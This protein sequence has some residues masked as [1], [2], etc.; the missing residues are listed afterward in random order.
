[1]WEELPSSEP[2]QPSPRVYKE[3]SAGSQAQLV[4][5]LGSG[6]NSPLPN[7]PSHHRGYIRSPLLAVR[8]SR[9]RG[10]EVGG[11]PLSRTRP[12]I[13]EESTA[14]GMGVL[15]KRTPIR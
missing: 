10:S 5:G 9:F 1:K 12:A 8:L 4:P 11:T 7:P 13:T 3:P 2:A 6:R 14:A 15:G